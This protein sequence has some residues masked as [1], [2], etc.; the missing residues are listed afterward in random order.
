MGKKVAWF[1]LLLSSYWSNQSD[2]ALGVL[3]YKLC[4]YT[5]PFEEDSLRNIAN[6]H[7]SIPQTPFFSNGI[8]QLIT[9]MLQLNQEQRPNIYQV[10][11]IVSDMMHVECPIRN[12]SGGRKECYQLT[13]LHVYLDLSGETNHPDGASE[14]ITRQKHSQRHSTVVPWKTTKS[15]QRSIWCKFRTAHFTY[16]ARK[17][18]SRSTITVIFTTTTNNNIQ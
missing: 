1:G 11:K 2:Q 8:R 17:W 7:Y 5:T 12:V 15:S 6:G 9:A 16:E 4:Y 14:W 18:I 3:L 13:Y 10:I